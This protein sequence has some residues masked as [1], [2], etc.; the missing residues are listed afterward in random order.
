MTS[1]RADLSTRGDVDVI[2]K[3]L[4][5]C[6][7][8]TPPLLIIGLKFFRIILFQREHE[9]HLPAA[10]RCLCSLIA[11]PSR[12]AA[13]PGRPPPSHPPPIHEYLRP[14]LLCLMVM[15]WK[16][17]PS[18]TLSHDPPTPGGRHHTKP[19]RYWFISLVRERVEVVT[20][21]DKHTLVTQWGWWWWWR[22]VLM[23][24][25]PN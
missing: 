23:S 16:M 20:A 24:C 8:L 6:C 14:P 22:Y 19:I 10:W 13:P 5:H 21:D 2:G 12:L 15:L 3:A 1:I 4:C 9:Q 11:F 18:V 25:A 17:M 7:L